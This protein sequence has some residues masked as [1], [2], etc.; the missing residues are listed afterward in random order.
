[1]GFR[2]LVCIVETGNKTHVVR[3]P[4]KEVMVVATDLYQG[5]YP[6]TY[7][8]NPLYAYKQFTGKNTAEI[9]LG[10]DRI[11]IETEGGQSTLTI[12]PNADLGAD[13]IERVF[14]YHKL[15]LE[16]SALKRGFQCPTND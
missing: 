12:R 2:D 9:N 1:M 11:S 10:L 16:S 14:N 5:M 3:G 7:D 4:T 15:E 6:S 8:L 13:S